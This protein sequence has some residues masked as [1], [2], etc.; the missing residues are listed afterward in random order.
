MWIRGGLTPWM[1]PDL[2]R[3]ISGCHMSELHQL[4]HHLR[5]TPSTPEGPFGFKTNP[6]KVGNP[7][8]QVHLKKAGSVSARSNFSSLSL[9]DLSSAEPHWTFSGKRLHF[10]EVQV[11]MPIK[12]ASPL[13]N[14][15]S[16]GRLLYL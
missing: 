16:I 14:Y 7:W 13:I 8:F 11:Q 2:C 10:R 12:A 4:W 15:L 1:T 6:P 3:Q 5:F 9:E